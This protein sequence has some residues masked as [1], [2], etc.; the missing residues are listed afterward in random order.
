MS[1]NLDTLELTPDE[2]EHAKQQVRLLAYR[3]WQEGGCPLDSALTFWAMAE[4]EWMC[5]QYV[6]NRH[7]GQSTHG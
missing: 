1:T 6:P 5:S 7:D 4:R 2:L 3:H